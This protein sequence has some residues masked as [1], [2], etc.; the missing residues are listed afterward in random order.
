MRSFPFHRLTPTCEFRALL[1]IHRRAP[2]LPADAQ[3]RPTR[4]A[5]V[6][7]AREA[8]GGE[9]R[10]SGVRSLSATG[11]PGR[12]GRQPRPD[13]IRDRLRAPD[14]YARK[15][16]IPAQESGPT[17]LCFNGAELIHCRSRIRRPPA[18]RAARNPR[19]RVRPQ[20]PGQRPPEDFVSAHGWGCLPRPSELSV[21]L[22]LCRRGRAPQGRP[23][24]ST[25][26]APTISRCV[27]SSTARR[28]C[29]SWSAG[30]R[31]RRRRERCVR[32][33][34]PGAAPGGRG[35]SPGRGATRAAP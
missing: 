7:A 28:T 6:A 29:R 14:R 35:D 15:D 11:R 16:E 23:T 19:W 22:H 25:P 20:E 33:T 10:L 21:D 3:L 26:A 34:G 4:R 1:L 13:R 24:C 9:K 5:V 12:C 30:C 32:R 31:R 17:T 2:A 27:C 18:R 8:L